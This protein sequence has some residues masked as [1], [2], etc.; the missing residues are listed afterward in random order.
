MSE[1]GYHGRPIVKPPVWTW[2]IPL[3]FFVGGTAG[4]S[5][6]IAA[7]SLAGDAPLGLARAALWMAFVGALLSPALLVLDLGRPAR[8]LNMLRVLKLRSPMSVGVWTL[9]LF[10]VFSST[11]LFLFEGFALLH[12]L[13]FP[14]ELLAA[15]LWVSMLGG[16]ASGALLATY[17]GV[18]LAVTAIPAWSSHR[19][20]LPLHFGAAALGSAAALLELG[21]SSIAPLAAI[22]YFAAGVE[23]VLH[24]R[25]EAN[26]S[27]P[28][29]RALR[30][31]RSG[32]LLRIA[33]FSSGPLA[34]VLRMLGAWE[35]AALVFIAGALI[36]RYGWIAAGRASAA[37]PEATLGVRA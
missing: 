14:R 1:A 31:G 35:L 32:L 15:L 33:G 22:G 4:M 27:D 13:G 7:C 26:T 36:S 3:Y 5:A 25:I 34:L 8:F 9:V 11:S 17:T 21:G 10:S 20:L 28:R 37:D 16:A 24:L 6:V 18:L 23:T 30:Q 2:E 29:D 12:Q 19:A